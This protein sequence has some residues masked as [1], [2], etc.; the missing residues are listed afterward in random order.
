MH[1]YHARQRAAER[2]T[3][4]QLQWTRSP[5]RAYGV[6]SD[7][8]VSSGAARSRVRRSGTEILSCV[9]ATVPAGTAASYKVSLSATMKDMISPAA[10][11][12]G[13]V[14]TTVIIVTFGCSGGGPP[15]T[16]AASPQLERTR[17]GPPRWSTWPRGTGL[18]PCPSSL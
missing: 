1:R 9:P 6:I 4:P 16:K 8:Y 10:A 18:Y 15:L 11:P 13:I 14:T 5:P 17:Q 12:S 7:R 3:R 2:S